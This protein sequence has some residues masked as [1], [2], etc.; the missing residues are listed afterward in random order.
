MVGYAPCRRKHESSLKE[1]TFNP[2]FKEFPQITFKKNMSSQSKIP[3]HTR[4]QRTI[5]ERHQRQ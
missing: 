2:G 5:T 1:F 3:K 4:T